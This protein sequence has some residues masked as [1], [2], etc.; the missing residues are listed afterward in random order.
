M[1]DVVD[2]GLGYNYITIDHGGFATVYGHVSEFNVRPGQRVQA[3]DKIGKTGGMPGLR[4]GGSSTG[5]H[6]HFGVYVKGVPVDP[7]K[8]L[9]K[10]QG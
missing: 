3:G 6:L 2:H 9:P 5:P 8:Y 10:Y 1:K 7:L 4:G